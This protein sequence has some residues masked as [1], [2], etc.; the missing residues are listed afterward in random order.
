MIVDAMGGKASS[1]RRPPALPGLP[2]LGHALEFQRDPVGLFR[3]GYER[4]GPIFGA[5]LGPQRAA[6]ILGPEA[7][8]FFFTETDKLLSMREVYRFLIPMFGD[9]LAFVAEPDEYR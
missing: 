6:V 7:N 8:R 4:L 1:L 5:R 9:K 2:V 3:R